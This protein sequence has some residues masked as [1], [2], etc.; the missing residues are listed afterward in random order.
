MF[1]R[2]MKDNKKKK[3]TQRL[4]RNAHNIKR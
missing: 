1:G 2:E 3:E 4:T